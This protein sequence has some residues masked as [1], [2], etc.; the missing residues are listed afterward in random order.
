M[1]LLVVT[2]LVSCVKEKV[3]FRHP[4]KEMV[5]LP[6]E[7]EYSNFL[8]V[9]IN[10]EWY[11]MKTVDFLAMVD[12]EFLDPKALSLRIIIPPKDYHWISEALELK[13]REVAKPELVSIRNMGSMLSRIHEVLGSAGIQFDRMT[14][15]IRFGN[16]G[17]Y[18]HP[19]IGTYS[20]GNP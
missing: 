11:D 8:N 4:G 7:L 2:S 3:E 10:E 18:S 5:E 9:P 15:Y 1:L 14:I 13:L 12:N 20:S 16:D 19:R 17:Y 6:S